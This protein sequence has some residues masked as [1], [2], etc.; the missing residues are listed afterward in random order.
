MES[1]EKMQSSLKQPVM[2]QNESEGLKLEEQ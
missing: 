2:L 1:D